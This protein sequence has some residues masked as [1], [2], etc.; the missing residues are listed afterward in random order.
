ML[1]AGVRFRTARAVREG[2]LVLWG[3]RRRSRAQ[4]KAARGGKFGSV[5]VYS[6]A[7][8]N[9]LSPIR[10]KV[11]MFTFSL[12]AGLPISERTSAIPLVGRHQIERVQV[13]ALPAQSQVIRTMPE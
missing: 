8:G 4:R 2:D 9:P 10:P 3:G 13:C 5:G 7:A 11:P 6:L 12:N 1:A